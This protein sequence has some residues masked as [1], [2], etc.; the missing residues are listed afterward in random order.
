MGGEN[1]AHRRRSGRE[2]LLPFGDFYV[3]S[4]SAH[5]RDH[6]GSARQPALL[7]G[8]LLGIG[9]R[10]LCAEYVGYRLASGKPRLAFE[11]DESPRHEFAVIRNARRDGEERLDLLRRGRGSL[12]LTWL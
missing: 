6:Q 10:V 4:G 1:E 8:E 2:Y 5:H 7:D 12:E 3:R 9:L 11:D